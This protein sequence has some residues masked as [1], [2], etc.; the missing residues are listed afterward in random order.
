[1]SYRYSLYLLINLQIGY[2]L[3]FL[4]HGTSIMTSIRILVCKTLIFLG[5]Y[6]SFALIGYSQEENP[7]FADLPFPVKP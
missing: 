1:M 6:F 5:I 4:A 3:L 2:K 7:A